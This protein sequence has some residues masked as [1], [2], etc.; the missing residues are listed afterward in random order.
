MSEFT[1]QT[2]LECDIE[3]AY[4]DLSALLEKFNVVDR[5]IKKLE[6]FRSQA[7]NKEVA[8]RL[9]IFIDDA[10]DE[11]RVLEDEIGLQKLYIEDLEEKLAKEDYQHLIR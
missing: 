7:T 9:N 3:Q 2:Q 10:I 6:V 4:D 1:K 5:D 8:D 11:F